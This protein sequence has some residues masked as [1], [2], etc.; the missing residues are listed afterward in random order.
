MY[1]TRARSNSMAN[2]KK[3]NSNKSDKESA[4]ANMDTQLVL[5]AMQEMEKRIV[6]ERVVTDQKILEKIELLDTNLN[7]TLTL[8]TEKMTALEEKQSTIS[9]DL[10]DLKTDFNNLK[11]DHD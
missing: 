8:H 5:N 3:S 11:E 6:A 7:Q 9:S 1:Q 4:S 10:E 2:D